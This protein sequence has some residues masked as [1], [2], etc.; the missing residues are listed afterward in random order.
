MHIQILFLN[1]KTEAQSGYY[2]YKVT[3]LFFGSYIDDWKKNWKGRVYL[4]EMHRL[5]TAWVPPACLLIS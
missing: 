2:F 4:L 1:R 3:G 5:F